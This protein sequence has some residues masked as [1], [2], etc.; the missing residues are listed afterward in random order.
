MGGSDV[1]TITE[2]NANGDTPRPPLRVGPDIPSV[3]AFV[4]PGAP[5]DLNQALNAQE[6]FTA[7]NG[8]IAGTLGS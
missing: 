3:D 4:L 7:V 5:H 2:L 1:L 6:Y 8:W